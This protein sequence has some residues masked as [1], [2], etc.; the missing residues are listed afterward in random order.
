MLAHLGVALTAKPEWAAD[1]LSVNEYAVIYAIYGEVATH[2][3]RFL[4]AEPP[5]AG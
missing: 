1:L 4:G 2:E 5:A 3:A